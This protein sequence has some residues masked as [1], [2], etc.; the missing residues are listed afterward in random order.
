MIKGEHLYSGKAK[1]LFK[2]DD[3]KYLIM[4]FRDDATAFNGI[5][6]E[7][8]ARK[9]LVNNAFNAFIMTHLK[10][11]GIPVH[12]ERQLSPTE[13]LVKHLK[14]IPVESVVRNVAAG[15]ISKRLGIAEGLS[16]NPPTLEF[17]LKNDM[18][19]DPMINE[20]H[21][22]T[23]GWADAADVAQ[24][25]VLTFKVNDILKRLFEKAGLILVD[26]KLEFGKQDGQLMLGDEFT[27][28]GCRI[29]DHETREKLDK[30]RFRRDLGDV[31]ESYEIVAKRLGIS[32][33]D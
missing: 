1:T 10:A 26:F 8:F 30:D 13:S 24:M 22:E 25:K 20:Y 18:L 15:G 16:L 12:F 9:G 3:P 11:E 29:W 23:F 27:P 33:V 17:F 5:K 21:I 4:L 2:T 19:N 6:S 28:D 32:I 7:K 14:M 31:I